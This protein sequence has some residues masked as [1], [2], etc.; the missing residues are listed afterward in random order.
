MSTPWIVVA[1]E[2]LID[3]VRRTDG[4]LSTTP[5]GGPYNVA[6]TLGRLGRPVAFLGRLSTDR[7]GRTL[8]EHLA[9]DGVDLRLAPTTHDPTL[10]AEAELDAAGVA[11]YRFQSAGT[12]AVGLLPSDLPD[13]LPGATI[14]L[15]VGTLGLVLEPM[16]ATIETLVGT[17]AP[18]ILVMADPNCR[19]SA[20]SDPAGYRARLSRILGR[21]DLV[22]ASTDDLD[23]LAPGLDAV[24][25][26]RRLLAA[27]PTTALVTDGPRP[28]RIVTAS[29]VTSIDAPR[30]RVVD[31]IGAG[32]AFGAG[33]LAA[34][35]AAGRGRSDLR[36]QAA[37][38]EA[39]RFAIEVGAR[40]VSREGAEPPTLAE[41]SGVARE[42][43]PDW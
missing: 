24:T 29:D 18:D 13:G 41:L 25:A 32:D 8:R 3:R 40:I 31:T 39:T 27:G 10:V 19:P 38:R 43:A 1:G 9:A 28:V 26:A 12:A 11:S 42:V 37:V 4:S 35:T 17:A 5:G 23:W 14:A 7:D 21:V 34:W 2:S 15:H 16:A 36:D 30:V 20:I 6:R 33:F 22:K